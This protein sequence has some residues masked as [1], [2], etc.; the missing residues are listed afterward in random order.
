MNDLHKGRHTGE[1]WSWL[2]D[3]SAVFMLLF[4]FTG[5]IILFQQLK[6]RGT[7]LWLLMWG[8]ATPVLIYLIWVP[9]IHL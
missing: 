2:I 5:L 6:R 8:T 9:R 4:S 3:I 7:G 1:Y